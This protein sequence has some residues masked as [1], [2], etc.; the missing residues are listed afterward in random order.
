MTELNR[1]LNAVNKNGFKYVAIAGADTMF[2]VD[3]L[4]VV[5]RPEKITVSLEEFRE[6]PIETQI[7]LSTPPAE[8]ILDLPIDD[9]RD[10]KIF[11][12]GLPA[13]VIYHDENTRE[14]VA[15]KTIKVGDK[16][17]VL[18]NFIDQQIKDTDSD[19]VFFTR[20][21]Y[22]GTVKGVKQYAIDCEG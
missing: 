8:V 16:P 15:T 2:N 22:T 4:E 1:N 9:L 18:L 12:H 7:E 10:N 5:D 3:T 6:L 19:H 14:V 17:K 20:L 13:T 11:T 21:I